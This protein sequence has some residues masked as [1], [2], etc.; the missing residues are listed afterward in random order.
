MSGDFRPHIPT[1]RTTVATTKA[2]VF[3]C[4]PYTYFSRPHGA[5][6]CH[7]LQRSSHATPMLSV[8]IRQTQ[9]A[10]HAKILVIN[11]DSFQITNSN[12]RIDFVLITTDE[13]CPDLS[14]PRPMWTHWWEGIAVI[15][16]DRR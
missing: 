4:Q 12:L 6:T 5:S 11:S 7:H 1:T 15:T 14:W 16:S 13:S 10:W 8:E 2:V 9:T 3:R